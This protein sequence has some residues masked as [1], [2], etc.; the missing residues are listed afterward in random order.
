M[1]QP[2]QSIPLAEDE[3]HRQRMTRRLYY[4]IQGGVWGGMA[5]AA[6]VL[7]AF[8]FGDL[9]SGSY[10][11]L[12]PFVSFIVQCFPFG[13]GFLLTHFSRFPIARF[14]WKQLG[15]GRLLP[16]VF[17]LSMVLGLVEAATLFSAAS[18][19]PAGSAKIQGFFLVWVIFSA[20]FAAWLAAY[21]LYHVSERSSRMEENGLRLAARAQEAELNALRSQINP[22]FI[23]NSLNS[24]RALVG[25]DPTR[26]RLA[27][28]QLANLLR[29]SLESSQRDAVSL[30]AELQMARDYLALEQVR[31]EERLRVTIDVAPE[32]LAFR[33]PPMLLQTLVE[34]AVKYGIAQE[35]EGGAITV[36]ARVEQGRLRLR[37]TNPGDLQ[38]A[39]PRTTESTGLGLRNAT[40]RLRLLFG[41]GSELVLRSGGPHLVVAEA[42]VPRLHLSDVSV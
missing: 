9:K 2:A 17:G 36:F 4:L 39:D 13:T 33:V 3:S 8:H 28:T 15:T 21:F 5:L 31:F 14:R 6:V 11:R 29:Y 10:L 26:A 16:R 34:N 35:E 25:E 24:L 7:L 12:H 1:N 23:F 30:E 42:L 40:E 22:H 37:V 20:L 27:V 41:P 18:L 19:L 32:A 38:L